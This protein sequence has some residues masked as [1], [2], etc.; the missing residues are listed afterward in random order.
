MN[1]SAG[2]SPHKTRFERADSRFIALGP[3]SAAYLGEECPFHPVFPI[4]LK[5]HPACC[6]GEGC[7]CECVH[8][9]AT[10][11][12]IAALLEDSIEDEGYDG[13][14]T[15]VKS[16]EEAER[17]KVEVCGEDRNCVS[18]G[19]CVKDV[20]KFCYK[21]EENQESLIGRRRHRKSK[22]PLS[23]FSSS[24][25]MRTD[26]GKKKKEEQIVRKAIIDQMKKAW[27]QLNALDA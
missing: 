11:G 3:C 14:T 9:C 23:S 4:S 8:Q 20:C 22:H 24:N 19:A 6:D 1:K 26:G 2:F 13:C 10:R 15:D 16:E 5:F 27:E 12:Q 21:R 18:E 7:A 17:W 25:G